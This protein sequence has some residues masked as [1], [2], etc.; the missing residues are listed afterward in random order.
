MAAE[1]E[2]GPELNSTVLS[3]VLIFIPGILCYGI[4]AALAEKKKRDNVTMLLQIFMYGTF[5]YLLLA[6]SHW[7]FPNFFPAVDGISI[8]KPAEINKLPIDPKLI[9]WASLFGAI[10]G[11]CTSINLNRQLLLKLCRWLKLT[12]RFGDEDV[13]TL[14]LNSTDSDNWVTIRHKERNLVYQGYVSGFSSGGETR[15]L[16]IINVRVYANEQQ[17]DETE[18]SRVGDGAL[19][20][21]GEIPFLYMSFKE[22]DVTLEFGENPDK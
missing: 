18:K 21:V 2:G 16:L 11:V 22:D 4:I 13:W 20:Q 1:S 7:V 10:L 3:L 12:E 5:S 8:L 9:A 19:S 6:C 15:E 14:L 17:S